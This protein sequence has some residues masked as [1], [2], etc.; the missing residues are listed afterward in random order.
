LTRAVYKSLKPDLSYP[1]TT[2]TN[3]IMQV[4]EG[5]S[6]L[7]VQRVLLV[8]VPDCWAT[9]RQ[10]VGRAVRFNGH[11][12]LPAPMRHVHVK[13]YVACHPDGSRTADQTLA[14][15]LQT[16]MAQFGGKMRWVGKLAVDRTLF[17]EQGIVMEDDA[18]P[19]AADDDAIDMLMPLT[20][21]PSLPHAS[22]PSGVTPPRPP[23]SPLP[24]SSHS[25]P[26]DE[27]APATP[28]AAMEMEVEVDGADGSVEAL[29][30]A[31]GAVSLQQQQ[32]AQ[33]VMTATAV[34]AESPAVNVN[35]SMEL[36]RRI[37]HADALLGRV[38]E[39][40][41]HTPLQVY[42]QLLS[43]QAGMSVGEHRYCGQRVCVGAC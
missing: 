26:A 15:K 41:H 1:A 42:N 21:A 9:L 10:R 7:G 11:S 20:V 24:P 31:M 34:V 2:T 27:E 36:A 16:E 38:H 28:D 23:R 13:M 8:D 4:S 14:A 18:M 37:A 19:A 22:S 40:Q 3:Q 43:T 25:P 12:P 6:F 17:A 5:E 30:M 29:S 35:G 32:P 33:A 39:H